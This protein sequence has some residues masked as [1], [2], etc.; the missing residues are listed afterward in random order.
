MTTHPVIGGVNDTILGTYQQVSA[1][2]A[3]GFFAATR[4]S[5]ALGLE[6]SM[7]TLKDLMIVVALLVGITSLAMA[8]AE[9]SSGPDGQLVSARVADNPPALG[10]T[11]GTS[12]RAARHHGTRH[13]RMYMMSV[14][15]T[16]KGS[17]LTPASNAK[18]LSEWLHRP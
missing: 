14:N 12:T 8:Q 7:I 4:G 18:P 3:K 13:H 17:K 1:A 16:H 11:S 9:G 10:S 2:A 6:G 5:G 15:R